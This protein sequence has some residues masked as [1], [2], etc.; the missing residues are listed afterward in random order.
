MEQSPRI[1]S[2]PSSKT[3]PPLKPRGIS[4]SDQ[5]ANVGTPVSYERLVLQFIY[6]LIDAYAAVGSQIRH[7]G[8]LPRFYKARSMIILEETALL[9]KVSNSVNN[10]ALMTSNNDASTGH[11][12]SRPNCD[13]SNNNRGG[14]SNIRGS[15]G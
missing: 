3:I 8:T 11:S 14:R 15:R 5:L 1:F 12:S 2:T 13:S 7:A 6:G 4:L 9:K 10:I